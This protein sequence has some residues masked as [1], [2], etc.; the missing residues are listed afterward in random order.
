MCIEL[1]GEILTIQDRKTSKGTAYKVL[2]VL[3]NHGKYQELLN[4]DDFSGT[5]KEVG[6]V[7]LPVFC[8]AYLSKSGRV[9]INWRVNQ[10]ARS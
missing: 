9:G 3:V 5:K 10:N 4:V 8:G 7:K 6:K 2:Q 1:D